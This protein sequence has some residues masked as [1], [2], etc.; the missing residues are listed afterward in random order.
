MTF[1]HWA[2]PMFASTGWVLGVRTKHLNA[3]LLVMTVESLLEVQESY[4]FLQLY[5]VS[6]REIHIEWEH[7]APQVNLGFDQSLLYETTVFRFHMNW[8]G[9]RS[10]FG[11]GQCEDYHECPQFHSAGRFSR[12]LSTPEKGFLFSTRVT[13]QLCFDVPC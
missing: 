10:Y 5:R 11:W 2:L 8:R 7:T 9:V 13:E 12:K 6:F 3:L 1:P 4:Q